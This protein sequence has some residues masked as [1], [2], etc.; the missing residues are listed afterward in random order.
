M[1]AGRP[2]PGKPPAA[3][4]RAR[5]LAS[6][7]EM[8]ERLRLVLDDPG[9]PAWLGALRFVAEQG[10][11][12]PRQQLE[13]TSEEEKPVTQVLVIGRQRIEF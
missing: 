7:D 13:V 1:P 12:K 6:R 3:S 4:W 5:E 2:T 11:G 10:Y 9:H 8:L